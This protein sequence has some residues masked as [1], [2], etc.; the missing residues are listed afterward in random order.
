LKNVLVITY[1]QTGQLTDI[2]R[3]VVNPLRAA[4][5]QVHVENLVPCEAFPWPWPVVD[6]IDAFPECVQLDPPPIRPLGIDPD[7]PFDLVILSYQVWYLSPSLP[8]T[9]FLKGGDAAR[10]LKGRPVVTLVACRNM[11]LS[12]QATVAGLVAAAGGE[13]RDHIALVDQGPALATFITTPRWVL[14]GRR[15]AFLGMPPAGVAPDDI[16]GAGRFGR[17]LAHALDHDRER[18]RA[19]MLTGLRAVSVNPRLAISERAGQRAFRVWS[20]LIRACGRRGEW[21]RRPL[22][23]LFAIYLVVM[24]VTVVPLSLF[25]QFLLAPLLKPRLQALRERLESPSGS[26]TFNLARH[27]S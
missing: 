13:L 19:P 3:E 14:S 24:I 8:V 2:V 4:G 26:E 7:T 16:R 1:S 21:R 23:L 18:S 27:E 25:L 17:A 15:D 11:W 22:L 10:L 5:H 20:R 12:A 6:F 9:A